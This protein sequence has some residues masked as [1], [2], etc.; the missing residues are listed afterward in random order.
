MTLKCQHETQENSRQKIFTKR[1][2]Y[3]IRLG[4]VTKHNDTQSVI[5][6]K[7]MKLQQINSQNAQINSQ[8]VQINSQNAQKQ[9]HAQNAQ[10]SCKLGSMLVP[11]NRTNTKPKNMQKLCT[12]CG[13]RHMG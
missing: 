1:S 8:K 11:T 12:Q 5:S 13:N 2:S 4:E 7:D 10:N 9:I 3:K 6:N